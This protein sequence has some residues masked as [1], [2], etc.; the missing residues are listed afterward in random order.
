MDVTNATDWLYSE[1]KVLLIIVHLGCQIS[2][3]RWEH[4]PPR[5][6][7]LLLWGWTSW[8]ESQHGWVTVKAR[9]QVADC[10]LLRVPTHVGRDKQAPS[11][12]FIKAPCGHSYKL[13]TSG[14]SLHLAAWPWRLSFNIWI[15]E[16]HKY[17]R[18]GSFCPGS[19]EKSNIAP[20]SGTW[21]Q[22]G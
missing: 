7:I 2:T 20:Q 8:S 14:K 9:C 11:G 1:R 3:T 12:P 5:T 17:P 16:R 18:H 21:E 19:W 22:D 13:L 15:L 4:Y 6:S 10:W